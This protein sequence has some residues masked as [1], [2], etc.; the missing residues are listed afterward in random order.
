MTVILVVIIVLLI[1]VLSTL[2]GN[3]GLMNIGGG[4]NTF[5]NCQV[6][7]TRGGGGSVYKTNSNVTYDNCTFTNVNN[8]KT[9]TPCNGNTDDYSGAAFGMSVQE[10]DGNANVTVQN[11]SFV[12]GGDSILFKN[13]DVG[14]LTSKNNTV[15]LTG[16][17]GGWV[18]ASSSQDVVIIPKTETVYYKVD[19]NMA[20][21]KVSTITRSLND[22][23]DE[24]GWNTATQKFNYQ[25][26]G[27]S[28]S[29]WTNFQFNYTNIKH[30]KP[31]RLH[32]QDITLSTDN[33]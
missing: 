12:S 20:T 19:G 25:G 30:G 18:D 10:D 7:N 6:E 26:C 8:E 32:I 31:G 27:E 15:T 5:K 9:T 33:S 28:E 24:Y 2:V 29:T 16:F 17:P 11:S 1:V 23:I 22:V 3:N 21:M 14:T 13:S 4:D